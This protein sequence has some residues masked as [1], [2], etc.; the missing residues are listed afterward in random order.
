MLMAKAAFGDEPSCLSRLSCL[1]SVLVVR[2]L[3]PLRTLRTLW[4]LSSVWPVHPGQLSST[5]N[6]CWI[7]PATPHSK[8]LAR[9][10]I[11]FVLIS[12]PSASL[13][14]SHFQFNAPYRQ[15]HSLKLGKFRFNGH[16]R[17][18]GNADGHRHTMCRQVADTWSGD[19]VWRLRL[20]CV[21]GHPVLGLCVVQCELRQFWCYAMR[22][23]SA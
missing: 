7:F 12:G 18:F 15:R 22:Q 17:L 5:A 1:P 16:T 2:S 9:L 6:C 23:P 13:S 21:D 8:I 11:D 3:W 19:I 14:V 20:S 4:S 10:S